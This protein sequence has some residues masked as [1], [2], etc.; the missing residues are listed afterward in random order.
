MI[1]Y[2]LKIVAWGS[3][4]EQGGMDKL[5]FCVLLF[6]VAFS[7]R[8]LAGPNIQELSPAQI[9]QYNADAVFTIYASINNRSFNPVGS[10]FFLCSTGIAVTNHHVIASWPYAF[11]RTHDGQRFS[12]SGYYSYGTAE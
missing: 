1:K 2:S 5:K 12:I 4:E 6:I 3:A 7:G 10:G 8:A 9:F 11:I